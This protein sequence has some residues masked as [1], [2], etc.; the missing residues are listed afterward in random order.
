MITGSI[1][2]L[3]NQKK[4]VNGVNR[5]M[6]KTSQGVLEG[7]SSIFETKR[8]LKLIPIRVQIKYI[9]KPK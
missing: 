3:S 7:A 8:L 4:V 1:I 2:V 6:I 9:L 5:E